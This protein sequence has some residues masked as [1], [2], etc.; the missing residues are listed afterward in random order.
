MGD[1]STQLYNQC[2]AGVGHVD[3]TSV[4]PNRI[5]EIGMALRF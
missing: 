3:L 4:Q 2:R 5:I 1:E